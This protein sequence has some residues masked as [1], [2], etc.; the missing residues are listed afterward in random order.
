MDVAVSGG[1]HA[2]SSLLIVTKPG[3]IGLRGAVG[4]PVAC[5]EPHTACSAR[6]CLTGYDRWS[7]AGNGS[8][9]VAVQSQ[10]PL[11]PDWELVDE[12][13]ANGLHWKVY[14]VGPD[15]GWVCPRLG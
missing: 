13:D 3:L 8:L 11:F 2:P 1:A 4:A 15:D 9:T 10:Q 6:S 14:D 7:L 5:A 12:F